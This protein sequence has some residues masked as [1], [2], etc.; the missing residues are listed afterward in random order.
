MQRLPSRYGVRNLAGTMAESSW[1]PPGSY[2]A[3]GRNGRCR[4]GQQWQ[5]SLP[6]P[7]G[8]PH[9]WQCLEY[10]VGLACSMAGEHIQLP[11]ESFGYTRRE[12]LGMCVVIGSCNYPFQI[13][14]WKSAPVL[15]CGNAM[16]FKPPSFMPLS[17]LLLRSTPRPGCPPPETSST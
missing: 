7:L 3:E 14:C 13:A 15:A 17:V 8:H 2:R 12:P 6:G 10:Y 5:V 4:D 11:G 9:S 1:R 16:I